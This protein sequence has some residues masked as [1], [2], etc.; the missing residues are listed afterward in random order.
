MIIFAALIINKL[1]PTRTRDDIMKK[2]LTLLLSAAMLVAIVFA[3]GCKKKT[4]DPSPSNGG[5]VTPPSTSKIYFGLVGY[6]DSLF[7]R[8]INPYN[9]D[10]VDDFVEFVNSTYYTEAGLLY[11]ADYTALNN[12][13]N[14]QIPK[15]LSKVSLITFTDGIDYYS[16]DSEETNPEGYA[17]KAEYRDAINDKIVNDLVQGNNIDAYT[18][19]LAGDE[20]QSHIVEFRENLEKLASHPDNVY[21]V[22]TMP[23]AADK[24]YQIA[25]DIHNTVAENGNVLVMLVL[26]CTYTI[27]NGG[28]APWPWPGQPQPVTPITP[29]IPEPTP[30]DPPITYIVGQVIT[31]CDN[32]WG[33]T[34][35]LVTNAVTNITENSANCGGTVTNNGGWDVLEAGVC[36]STTHNP[37]VTGNHVIGNGITSFT[38]ELT[39]LS[40]GTKYYARAYAI[41]SKGVGYGNEVSFTTEGDEPGGGGGTIGDF[42]FSV[43]SSKTVY[44][45]QGN[46][47][48]QAS[49]DTWRFAE[50]QYDRIG[51]A[52]SNISSTYS[53]WIDLFGWGTSGY[54]DTN[55]PYNVN[56]QPYSTSN[57][58]VFNDEPGYS[59]N[60]TGYGPSLDAA[61]PD[62]TGAG[63]NY[64]WG[65]YNAIS[66]GGNQAGQW[67][68]LTDDEWYYVLITRTTSSGMR[69]A[70]AIV[71]N[72]H[73]L[74]ILPDNWSASYYALNGVNNVSGYSDNIISA[75]TWQSDLEAHGA[76]FLPATGY[77]DG[78]E[79]FM[80]EVWGL[81]VG[82][83]GYYWSSTHYTGQDSF[84]IAGGANALC[85]M[86]PEVYQ[87]SLG[88]DRN[89]RMY[90]HA[91]RLVK[92]VH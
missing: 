78:H 86:S 8:E 53:G 24:F 39:G 6:N 73:G 4:D 28:G 25:D 70:L 52:N 82:P 5:G 30:A 81:E 50:H 76:V 69:Y 55:D 75:T 58:A 79:V 13:T 74:I 15:N 85:F 62:L 47:Q 66:N 22:N 9:N 46:L 20:A 77:R 68:T 42:Q 35:S 88:V 34:P 26:D 54:H 36:Y 10:W 48:Y 1:R 80:T 87:I 38:C 60:W 33:T 7:I 37:T 41:N 21:E 63:A 43:S 91:V 12:M 61:S 17:T 72:I 64:D 40:S 65:V 44:F 2:I 31:I 18:I 11:Y 51:T 32:G 67:R 59:L 89:Y 19:G 3:T 56:F 23:E 45:S 71:N 27:I 84:F 90:G 83:I 16:L 57:D 49:T 29:P 92:D 14:A